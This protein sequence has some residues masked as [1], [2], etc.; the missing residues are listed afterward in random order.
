M[1]LPVFLFAAAINA[2]VIDHT[3]AEEAFVPEK[4]TVEER[5]KP[6]PNVFAV[7]QGLYSAST[8]N[9]YGAKDLALKGNVSIGLV[10]QFTLSADGRTAYTTSTYAKRLLR[11]PIEAVLEE[12]DVETLTLK[13]EIVIPS[14]M[15]MLRSHRNMLQLSANGKYIFVQ[16]ATP[17][18][19]VTVVDLEAGKVLA[20]VPT[21][22]CWSIYPSTAGAK[23]SS[24]CG[25]GTI[26]SLEVSADGKVSEPARSAKIFDA[27]ADPLFT[28]AERVG[29]D[30]IFSSYN[31]NLYRISDKNAAP[32]LVEK[33]SYTEGTEGRWA[34]GGFSIMAYSEANDVLFVTMHPDAKDGSHKDPATEIWAIDLGARKVLSRSPVEGIKF[35]A[36]TSGKTPDLYGV[37]DS[38]GILTRFEVNPAGEF[39]VKPAQT[40]NGLMFVSLV[41]TERE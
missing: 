34:P 28:A 36:V 12:Y 21:P 40:V 13:R 41:S 1:R 30:L 4:L 9:V 16:N 10:S 38:D 3:M 14:K 37:N 24:L 5:I 33:F 15:A 22:G 11:G 27:D 31:G 19:S 39:T 32:K 8:V 7:T 20:E 35:I 25:D 23:F 2:L 26:I 17:A 18:T 6:G 29:D